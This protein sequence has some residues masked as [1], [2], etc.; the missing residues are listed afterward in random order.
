MRWLD[1]ITD[2]MDT[3]L[4]KLWEMVEDRKACVLQSMGSKTVGHKNKT[5]QRGSFHCITSSDLVLHYQKVF[6][7][8][9]PGKQMIRG[10]N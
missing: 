2:S 5:K 10:P 9:P 7:S 4:I 3:N 1:S 6:P 8:E